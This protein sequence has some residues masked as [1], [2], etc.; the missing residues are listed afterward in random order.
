M[1]AAW[2]MAPL[3]KV[4]RHRKEFVTIDDLQTYKRCRVQLHAQGVV[5]RDDVAGVEI[6]TKK[7]QVCLPGEFLVA[8]IDAKVGGFGIVPDH[9]AG[10][11]VSSH[12]FLFTLDE[13][14]LDRRFLDY[15]IRTPAFRDQVRAQGSTNYAAIRPA[16]VFDYV[17][18]LPPLEEQR[19]IVARI[20]AL[21]AH[22]EGAKELRRQASLES[23]AAINSARRALIGHEAASDWIPLNNYVQEIQNGWSPACDNRP[24]GK[25]EWGVLKVGAVS[26]GRYNPSENKAL[27]I[28]L[29]PR[30]EN[31]VRPGD[32]LMGRANTAQL[33]GACAIVDSTPPRLMLCDKIFR[34]VFRLH[35]VPDRRYLEHVLKSPALRV[36]IEAA[37]LGHRQR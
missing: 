15:F 1:N 28:G 4:L 27:P 35:S 23:R 18:P 26:S 3:G 13:E 11:V 10:A 7:Q 20:E 33:T 30:Q 29:E 25:S 16:D 21:A 6:K 22:V 19:R 36:Q 17:I 24:A 8:E 5:L 32:F 14:V 31:E 9:L 37:Q 12:Y 2:P 34:F